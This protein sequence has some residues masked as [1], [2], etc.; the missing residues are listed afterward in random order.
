MTDHARVVIIG[1]GAVGCSA[2]YHLAQLGW[3]DCLLLER[4]ELI[5][6][7]VEPH[8]PAASAWASIR[9]GRPSRPSCS[10]TRVSASSRSI[11][12]SSCCSSS[13]VRSGCEHLRI[14]AMPRADHPSGR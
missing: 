2:L 9:A 10:R 11:S 6:A 8:L 5:R 12:L 14:A 7:V 1:G 3:T 4:D 13:A